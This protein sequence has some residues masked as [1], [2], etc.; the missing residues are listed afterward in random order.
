MSVKPLFRLEKLHIPTLTVLGVGACTKD[1]QGKV[2]ETRTRLAARIG[3][4]PI[5]AL[6][7]HF[8]VPSMLLFLLLFPILTFTLRPRVLPKHRAGPI[9]H[10]TGFREP[11]DVTEHSQLACC[12][13]GDSVDASSSF[14][15]WSAGPP[16]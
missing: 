7:G 8:P 15:A 14:L 4:E 1:E 6:R 9:R 13:K 5:G 3:P 11:E 16:A 12:L 2:R 10:L